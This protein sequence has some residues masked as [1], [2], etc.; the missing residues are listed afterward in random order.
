[1]ITLLSRLFLRDRTEEGLRKGCG[2]LCGAVGVG[3]NLL[4]ALGKLLAGLMSGSIAMLADAANNL[5]DAGSSFVSLLGFLLAGQKPDLHHP[6]GHGRMEY[7][8]GLGVSVLILLMGAELVKSSLTRILHPAPMESPVGT[9]ALILLAS[10]GVK[11]YMAYYNRRIGKKLNSAVLLAAASDS[12]GDCAA[13]A[14]VLLSSAAG[15]YTD[16]PLDGWAGLLV[17]G[18]IL[19]SG[20][21]AMRSTVDPLLGTPPSPEF[22]AQIKDHVLNHS[23]ILG[24]HDL[25]VHDY[26][27]GRRMVSFHA[28]VS[29]E[30][31]VLTLHDAV[32]RVE[33]ELRADLGCEV[34]IHMD[35]LASDSQTKDFRRRVESLARCID[36]E[37]G[38]HD[39]RMVPSQNHIKLI[40]DAVVPFR[41][42]LSDQEVEEKFQTAVRALDS[43]CEAIVNV[44]RSY[45]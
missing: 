8:A 2:I 14:V 34:V 28:E 9:A 40:F 41:F 23:D 32:D 1:M 5:S 39:F 30:Q 24:I 3:L 21:Q 31:D 19:W 38:V 12:L 10:I 26:G 22:V 43:R 15:R 7:L 44:E 13:T 20:V 45:T 35:P 29:A 17:A 6:F 36:S 42:R 11:L 27:P 18:V 25:I 4:L 37:I 33:R 16:L